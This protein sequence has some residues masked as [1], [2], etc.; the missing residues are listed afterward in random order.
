MRY[1]YICTFRNKNKIRRHFSR[2]L[3]ISIFKSQFRTF[4][5]I[6]I[7]AYITRFRL[8][9]SSGYSFFADSASQRPP[10][11]GSGW[12]HPVI[13]RH[14]KMAAFDLTDMPPTV[15]TGL[16]QHRLAQKIIFRGFDGIWIASW[17]LFPISEYVWPLNPRWRPLIFTEVPQNWITCLCIQ[18]LGWKFT[19]W[20]FCC[21]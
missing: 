7:F 3:E 14:F 5:R 13:F 18:V 2:S 12:W 8:D 10:K 15:I 20:G 1:P 17:R 21:Y 19:F 11:S 9:V 6:Y 16:V 4:S